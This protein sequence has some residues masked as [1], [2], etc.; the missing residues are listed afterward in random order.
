LCKRVNAFLVNRVNDR[1]LCN[2]HAAANRFT[3]GH[4]CHVDADVL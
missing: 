1:S 3:V 2:A 4:L